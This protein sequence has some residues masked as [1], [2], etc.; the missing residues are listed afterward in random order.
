MYRVAGKCRKKSLRTKVESS[1]IQSR[2]NKWLAG[3]CI[4]QRSECRDVATTVGHVHHTGTKRATDGIFPKCWALICQVMRALDRDGS[5]VR[6]AP[7]VGE[8]SGGKS[9]TRWTC[10][11]D[12]SYAVWRAIR[13][14]SWADRSAITFSCV[15][16][17]PQ[18]YYVGAQLAWAVQCVTH[19]LKWP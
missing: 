10:P 4:L 2:R 1:A 12:E 11:T 6:S 17:Y 16:G 15:N 18:T 9:F 14:F 7:A 13:H 5:T 8:S 3:F 19:V